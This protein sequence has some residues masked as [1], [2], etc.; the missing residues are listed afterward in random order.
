MFVEKEFYIGFADIMSMCDKVS[1]K[2]ILTYLEDIA[3]IHSNII[4]CGLNDVPES[5]H[6]WIILGWKVHIYNRPIYGETIKIKTWSKPMKN[7]CALRDF[8]IFNK[9][10]ELIGIATSKWVYLEKGQIAKIPKEVADL[11]KSEPDYHTFTEK[12]I[13]KLSE[14]E[15]ITCMKNIQITRSMIDINN[16]VHNVYYLDIAD[17]AIPDDIYNTNEFNKFQIMY[18]TGIK[19][20]PNENYVNCAYTNLEKNHVVVIKDQNRST[21]HAIVNYELD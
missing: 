12:E 19:R 17:E 3:G 21:L 9:D 20:L 14:P 5:K 2:A 15:E 7:C 13:E 10:S 18:K 4:G 8:E 11:Y 6:T 1:N 16:H